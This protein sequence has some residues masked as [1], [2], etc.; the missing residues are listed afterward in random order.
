MLCD[1]FNGFVVNLVE[2]AIIFR[3]DFFTR[4]QTV[5]TVKEFTAS[6][7]TFFRPSNRSIKWSHKH[8]INTK[9]VGTVL[10]HHIV[11]V[12]NVL[13]RF[14]HLGWCLLQLFPCFHME[15]RTVTFFNLVSRHKS[16]TVVTIACS[17]NHPLI[18]EFLE[19]FLSWNNTEVI[20]EFVP[21]TS[22]KQ[23]KYS[24]LCS[25]HI[26]IYWQPL[27]EKILISQ[28]LSIVWVNI[29]EVVPA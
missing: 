5:N 17:Q 18:K 16:P 8:F 22:V 26:D 6:F 4:N 24:M 27:F 2:S 15:E 3:K 28:F 19:W 13:K 21:E 25:T 7:Q 9:G 29:A 1:S 14:R 10:F 20:E 12:N 23:V 11:W